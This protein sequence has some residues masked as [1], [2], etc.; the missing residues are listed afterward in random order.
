MKGLPLFIDQINGRIVFIGFH[1]GNEFSVLGHDPIL[2][3]SAS[4]KESPAPPLPPEFQADPA[5]TE[6]EGE[7][8]PQEYPD[9]IALQFP[10]GADS[11]VLPYFL[12]GD[13][14]H[15]VNLWKWISHPNEVIEVYA[16]GLKRKRSHRPTSQQVQSKV[17]FR[18]GQYQLVMKRKLATQDSNDVQFKAG[19]T[20]PI[21]VNAWDGSEGEVETRKAISSWFE[22]ILE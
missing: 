11:T 12:N 8:K 18:Y 7:P 21:A 13:D 9:A 5:S 3:K 15:R 20:I 14:T 6:P 4:V 19:R 1:T 22:M 2:S 16:Q 17:A 10:I